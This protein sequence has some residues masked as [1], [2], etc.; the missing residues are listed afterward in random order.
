MIL[1]CLRAEFDDST[2]H[3]S[4]LKVQ[5]QATASWL[6]EEK[7]QEGNVLRDE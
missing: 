7:N 2:T 3:K 6:L 5:L 4:L 1:G